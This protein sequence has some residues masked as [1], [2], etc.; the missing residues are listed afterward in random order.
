MNNRDA[1]QALLDGKKMRRSILARDNYMRL[2]SSGTLVD[3]CGVHLTNYFEPH[4][5]WEI[6]DEPKKTEKMAP[7]LFTLNGIPHISER[8]FQSEQDARYAFNC[9]EFGFLRWL[10]DTHAVEVEVDE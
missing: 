1:L 3:E 6:Y 7:A 4:A 5:L 2:D 8:L 9:G 10:I